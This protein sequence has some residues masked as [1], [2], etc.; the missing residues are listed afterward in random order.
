M[1]KEHYIIEG[2]FY[3]GD[4]V[5]SVSTLLGSCVAVVVWHPKIKVGGMCHIVLPHQG[6]KVCSNKY[7]N[8]A[9]A[10]FIRC[11]KE[12]NTRPQDYLTYIYGGGAMF[13]SSIK[14]K[15]SIGKRNVEVVK[16]MLLER[17]FIIEDEDTCG[18]CYRKIKLD[19]ATGSVE[20]KSVDVDE[21]RKAILHG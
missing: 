6:K 4:D 19:I 3:F 12:V 13:A 1:T 14:N 5:K 15:N 18:N 9:I 21:S 8:C 17:K 10:N 7:A 11:V 2:E 20:L 16:K